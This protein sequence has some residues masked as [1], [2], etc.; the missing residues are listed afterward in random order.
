MEEY[1]KPLSDI[2]I[3]EHKVIILEGKKAYNTIIAFNDQL[4]TSIYLK[5]SQ[6]CTAESRIKY[7]LFNH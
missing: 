2:K 7:D 4:F 3:K 6:D 5:P 1:L